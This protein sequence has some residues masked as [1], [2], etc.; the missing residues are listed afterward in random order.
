MKRQR[1][2]VWK[3][4]C[5]H[6]DSY[7]IARKYRPVSM[8]SDLPCLHSGTPEFAHASGDATTAALLWTVSR[9]D[10]VTFRHTAFQLMGSLFTLSLRWVCHRQ[11]TGNAMHRQSKKVWVYVSVPNAM[12]VKNARN[13]QIPSTNR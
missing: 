7:R 2:V 1:V 3:T 5:K 11:R 6:T 12:I 4:V 10:I 9:T 8:V 13:N